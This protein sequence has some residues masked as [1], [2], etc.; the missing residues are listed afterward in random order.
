MK[1]IL[2]TMLS[3][4]MALW[5]FAFE[6]NS[7]SQTISFTEL[8][9]VAAESQPNVQMQKEFSAQRFQKGTVAP[10]AV[11]ARP[12]R[13]RRNGA[14][15]MQDI[16]GSRQL[17]A[18]VSTSHVCYGGESPVSA[19]GNDSVKI[20]RFCFGDVSISAKVDLTSGMVTIPS[21]YIGTVSGSKV[22][23]CKMDF[24]KGVYDTKA[25]LR[26]HIYKKS[27]II[28]D[29]FGFFVTEGPQAGAYLTV[30]LM[31]YAAI[32]DPNATITA[33]R[34]T[35][36]DNTL[37]TDNRQVTN[38]VSNSFIYPVG[39]DRLRI[40]KVPV[41]TSYSDLT[42][43]LM[44]DGTVLID[45]QPVYYH[46]LLGDYN[47][48]NMTEKVEG[49]AVKF[50]ISVLTPIAVNYN[51]T[52]RTLGLGSYGVARTNGLMG[53]YESATIAM[54]EA[55]TFPEP[56][57]MNL[58]GEGTA[59]KP[60]L[61]KS[62][63]DFQ[64]L[65][66]D[67]L[68]NTQYRTEATDSD[69]E[70]YYQVYAGK[71]FKLAADIDFGD[72][73][74]N[75]IGDET[76]WFAGS[77]NGDGHTISNL[78]IE[79]FAYDYCGLFSRL[80]P[81]S[82]VS[83]LKF[84]DAYIT[85]LGY[86]AGVLAGRS[87]GPIS[88]VEIIDSR[89]LVSAGYNAGMLV[90]YSHAPIK[91]VNVSG[92]YILSLG[93]MGGIAGRS[94]ANITDCHVQGRVIQTGKQVFSGGLVGHQTKTMIDDPAPVISNCSFTGSVQATGDEVGLGG[95]MGGLSYSRMENCFA[96]AVVVNA[97]AISA[98]IGGLVGT[99]YQSEL[100]DCYVSG[101]VR[102]P[103]SVYCGGLVGH[104]TKSIS[105][106]VTP[107]T[108]TNCYSSAMLLTKS[109]EAT[110]GIA[111]D[112]TNII[113]TDSYFDNQ[114]GIVPDG[115]H[116]LSTADLT[117]AKLPQGFSADKWVATEGMYPRI[118]GQEN[119]DAAVVSASALRL[120]A[121]ENV[122]DV[123]SDFHYS[124]NDSVVWQAIFEDGLSPERGY[125]FTFDKGI[126]RLNYDQYTDTIYV[127]KGNASKYYFV[128]IAPVLFPGSGTA[129]NP[130]IIS[131]ADDLKKFSDISNNARMTFTGR[132]FALGADIDCK[133][134]TLVP[135]CKDK[136]AKLF[137]DGSFDGRGHSIDNF[138]IVGVGFFTADN[139]TGTAVPGQV[140]PKDENSY[141][142]CGLFGNV[143]PQGV[144]RN[145][146]LGSKATIESFQYGGGIAGGSEGLIENCNNYATV[147]GYYAVTGGIVGY[148]KAK[149]VVRNCYNNG[150]ICIN[151]NTTGGIV[152]QAQQAT[153]ENCEN[154]GE[155]S[156]YWFNPY[157]KEASQYGAGGVVGYIDRS[158]VKNV[159]NSGKVS[160]YKQVGGIASKV[161]ATAA[162][163]ATVESALN[164]GLVYSTADH[165]SVGSIAGLNTL[166]EF[167]NC[168]A[169]KQIQKVGLVAG[170]LH[171]GTMQLPTLTLVSAQGYP[172]EYFA[173]SLW[174]LTAG[175]YPRL[176]YE[177]VP[178]QVAL[179]SKAVVSFTANDYASSM[180][181]AAP[182]AQGVNWS[183]VSG[184]IFSIAD[185][186]LNVTMPM[187]GCFTDTI[188]ASLDGCTRKLPLATL[189]PTLT[190]GDGT[191]NKPYLIREATEYLAIARFM[192]QFNFDYAGY[193][194]KVMSDLDFK[195]L[196][197]IPMGADGV[198]FNG[199]FD[200]NN[201]TV[202]NV[203]YISE[204]TDK[205]AV[206]RGFFGTVG[207]DGMVSNLKIENSTIS[208]YQNAGGISGI[209][210]GNI[211][212]CTNGATVSTL[213]T[214][215]AGGI[216]GYASTGSMFSTCSN[217]GAVTAKTNY[218]GGIIGSA[219]ASAALS[220]T[221]CSNAGQVKGASKIGG[222]VGSG[223]VYISDCSNTGK[224]TATSTYAGGILGEA[225]LPSGIK[226]SGNKGEIA[227][228]QYMAGIVAMSIAHTEDTPFEVNDCHN[229]ADMTSGTKGYAAGIG[230]QLKAGARITGCTNT[231]N[232]TGTTTTSTH[233]RLAGIV[234][235]LTSAA[236]TPSLVE[237]CSN[238]GNILCW[239]NSGGVIG[240][241][242]GD[243]LKIKECWNRGNVSGGYNLATNIGGILGNGP[244][245]F[246]DCW[247]SGNISATGKQAG[248][249]NGTNT[250]KSLTMTR[251]VNVGD[252]SAEVS[253]AGGMIGLG[254]ATMSNCY[255]MGA[256]SA[257]KAAGGLIGEPG[258]AAASSYTV[259][260][261][262]CYNSGKVTAE[263][264]FGNIMGQNASCKYLE[265]ARVYANTDT[266]SL[267]D[268]D[269][270]L[271]VT[272]MNTT[273]LTKF[274]ITPE[275]LL[276]NG[277][278]PTLQSF[279]ENELLNF[280]A[281][282]VL[283][284][285]DESLQAVK[286]TLTIGTPSG[287]KWTADGPLSIQGNIVTNQSTADN[288]AASL[289]LA[290]GGLTRTW[291]L[292]LLKSSGMNGIDAD[293][294]NV[295]R[296]EYY[297]MD[298]TRTT[299]TDPSAVLIE[300]TVYKDG[301]YTTR[302]T[303]NRKR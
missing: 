186:K 36:K 122:N 147:R 259:F 226:K 218:A 119:S 157:Q 160:S 267:T 114:I 6:R 113:I 179:N 69:G 101:Y 65:A 84:K 278:L 74:S 164:Y 233:M 275:F 66:S 39:T 270:T 83:N 70:K 21:Q 187:A 246:F 265:V 81:G 90:G 271:K 171:K 202:K 166:G 290:C 19:L 152:G 68:T 49:T 185:N 97:S 146:T 118:K 58:E 103:E 298:G 130:W 287:A 294:A 256:I 144:V 273:E 262:D 175:Q 247:N 52:D 102:N 41:T 190:E 42:A 48:Y 234:S 292:N 137:F 208:A 169:D 9:E 214:T 63:A 174:N 231:G 296:V 192:K 301:T 237:K 80:A 224:V 82:S 33:K 279:K 163:P 132:Y 199:S 196:D 85:S 211:V 8:S 177:K 60:W 188:V 14:W 18:H 254:R 288:T 201:K 297:R 194:F 46:S 50:S 112:I 195:D 37:T 258:A 79:N 159:V 115:T 263:S 86:T 197:F 151:G 75:P 57:T 198:M 264:N 107:T 44:T 220:V 281:A 154:T 280:Y 232:I 276:Q 268:Y 77:L 182:L 56:L 228:N 291:K 88:D 300:R 55:L 302:K 141:Y 73:L 11:E 286:T 249:I 15:Q 32:A 93:Y 289:T 250:A 252:I 217:T 269:N 184:G 206:G 110:R 180:M 183:L 129:E 285:K 181:S 13:L 127:S 7:T 150:F 62:A 303:I 76:H 156:A 148:L 51:K 12:V 24:R 170:G 203:N 78:A 92:A 255:N 153:V 261:H 167:V 91:N 248:G 212:G 121:G 109:T 23:L 143:G 277:T 99:T 111:G 100:K 1:R 251:C 257:P 155:V 253:D 45:P 35:F 158:T 189:N 245:Q 227:A 96:N 72:L 126:G 104:N 53:M 29:G 221:E 140:N 17:M 242:S 38:Q 108:I 236:K 2:M 120:S 176:K 283:P 244:A 142:Y 235:D 225:L 95:L 87:Y 124:T 210:Y 94:Y 106:D 213:G 54:N 284:A 204:A 136:A 10:E 134:D 173:D 135:I 16:T 89:V 161:N 98:Y 165:A 105:G 239:S 30:G 31:E 123:Q 162:I 145:V 3:V 131:T 178:A 223:S 34:I 67:I 125:A 241:C 139:V 215:G 209:C 43:R 216:T 295:L 229:T 260:V 243:S 133:G 207:Y 117:G 138:H 25:E 22:Y 240:A 20:D 168:L 172:K 191:M 219:P 27:I 230:A 71:Y 59:G 61:I 128:N 47:I 5:C 149:G 282:T 64:A 40:M 200:G 238:T 274:N 222:I 266:T 205:T 299:S 272:G 26:G 28:D 116:G 4:T 293:A 193:Y